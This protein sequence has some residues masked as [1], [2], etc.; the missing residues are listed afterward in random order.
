MEP[1]DEEIVEQVLAGDQA[2]YRFL[3]DR[4]ARSIFRMAYRM[5]GSSEDADDIV[6]E[7]FLR[8]YR[9]LDRFRSDAAFATWVYRIGM[10]CG[11]DVLRSRRRVPEE[12]VDPEEHKIERSSAIEPTQDAHM[13]R[14]EIR[15][16]LKD[17]MDQ[18][19]GNERTAFVMRHFEGMSIQ[20][21][22]EVLGTRTNAT[23]HTIF[24]AVRKLRETLGPLMEAGS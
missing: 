17:A 21:I 3:V 13:A 4:H 7:T 24:R 5:T 23:K 19:S 14:L 15:K 11:R 2:A 22:G 20:E 6:Q 1:S 10:N 9:R 8:A 16:Q 18:L 12:L